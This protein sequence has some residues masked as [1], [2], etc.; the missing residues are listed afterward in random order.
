MIAQ[1]FIENSI[2]NRQMIYNGVI[3]ETTEN[4]QSKQSKSAVQKT[5]IK[6][7]PKPSSSAQTTI[8]P[9]NNCD[10]HFDWTNFDDEFTIDD[11]NQPSSK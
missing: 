3:Q 2:Q 6:I 8:D 11:I 9:E 1:G 4:S 10:F 5:T 7:Q